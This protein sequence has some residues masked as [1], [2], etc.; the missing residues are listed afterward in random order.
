MDVDWL[1]TDAMQKKNPLN[2]SYQ[3]ISD[4]VTTMRV[5]PWQIN[6]ADLE[7]CHKTVNNVSIA[8][9]GTAGCIQQKN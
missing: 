6:Y 3:R 1:S 9:D 8:L 4:T 5:R 7:K 2:F